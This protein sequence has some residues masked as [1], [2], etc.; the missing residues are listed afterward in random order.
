[1]ELSG[2]DVAEY[3][4]V[5]YPEL[6]VLP[7]HLVDPDGR[8]VETATATA[9]RPRARPRMAAGAEAVITFFVSLALLVCVVAAAAQWATRE[10]RRRN[11]REEGHAG[12]HQ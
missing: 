7:E 5:V 1:M 9:G 2:L 3:G 12:D 6:G 11:L 10:Q 8:L 4:E